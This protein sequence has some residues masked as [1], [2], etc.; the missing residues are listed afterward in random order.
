[1]SKAALVTGA[2]RGIGRAIALRLAREGYAVAVNYRGS[3]AH[4]TSLCDEIAALGGHA[5]ALQADVAD[6]EQA[7]ALVTR[8]VAELGRLDVLVNNAGVTRDRLLAMMSAEDFSEVVRVNLNGC[9]NATRHAARVMMRQKSGVIVNIS[10]VIGIHGNAGQANYAAS[11]AGI[12]GLT[13]SA[14]KELGSRGIRV[15][16]VAPGYIQTDM[17]GVLT[18]EQRQ[19]IAERIVLGRLGE[20]D[21]VAALVGFL[22]SD[23]ASYITG[24]I[25]AVD[26]GLS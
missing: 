13:L 7:G 17:T 19:K 4:A 18:D 16:A 24:Q 25:I 23:A 11:K 2:S 22:C 9:F 14:A 21:D 1:M 3:E 20:A 5:V 12:H 6:Y 10:S 15:N 26:G 8:A